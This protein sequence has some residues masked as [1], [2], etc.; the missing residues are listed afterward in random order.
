MP[1]IPSRVAELIK[2]KYSVDRNT[3]KRTV[4]NDVKEKIE[5]EIGDSKQDDFFPQI[6]VKKWDNEVNL[7]VRLK[8]DDPEVPSIR[9]RGNVIEWVKSKREAHFYDIDPNQDFEDGGVEFEVVLNEKPES[10]VVEFTIETKGLDFFYQPELTE[11]EVEDGCVRPENVVGSYAVYHKTKK[12]NKI[13]GRYYKTGKAFHIYRPKIIDKSNNWVWGE[14]NIDEANGL[15][16]ITIPQSFLD[17]ASYPV[18]VDPTFGYT[19]G[20]ASDQPGN[21]DE[22]AF[23]QTYT[24][25]T[26]TLHGITAYLKRDFS[27]YPSDNF[28]FNF[29]N[30][31]SNRSSIETNTS[32]LT[33]TTSYAW[34]EKQMTGSTLSGATQYV[35]VTVDYYT[36]SNKYYIAYDT[37]TGL[38]GGYFVNIFGDTWIDQTTRNYSVYASYAGS[39]AVFYDL[40]IESSDTDLASHTPDLGTSW[41]VVWQ[42]DATKDLYTENADNTLR[43]YTTWTNSGAMYKA[44]ATYPGADY[45]V[46]AKYVGGASSTKPIYLFLRLQ[47]Q[48]NMYAL[49][50]GGGSSNTRMY[51]K[52]SGT[53]T[54]LGSAGPDPSPGDTVR[55][56]IQG[57]TLKYYFNGSLRDTQTDS[58]IT[59]AGNAG[60]GFGGGA[61]LQ[62]SNDDSNTSVKISDF[63]VAS[64]SSGGGTVVQ[65]VIGSGFI[66]FAR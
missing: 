38:D 65:D 6:K 51:K 19:S 59:S 32:S 66:P 53:W 52:V 63:Y 28:A 45:Y 3:F 36:S 44:N 37:G 2:D 56:E 9:T 10:N 30:S 39:D 21:G 34:Y 26:G 7:S 25:V 62:W 46:E 12:N 23:G 55:F 31:S 15:L 4:K 11:K 47:D 61:E 42:T 1:N 60:I 18:V 20:G 35:T 5:H 13:G 58:S 17:D 24:G 49:R 48:E 64:V 54:A 33:L 22:D 27:A 40:F 8:D 50:I 43:P 41:S 16:T 57:S 29:S 14:L